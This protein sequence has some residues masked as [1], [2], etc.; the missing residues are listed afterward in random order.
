MLS[1]LK[2]YFF[3]WKKCVEFW[4]T[5]KKKTQQPNKKQPQKTADL[6]LYT[7]YSY[8]GEEKQKN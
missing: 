5:D 8:V 3:S 1:Y 6:S 7:L 4:E 2:A